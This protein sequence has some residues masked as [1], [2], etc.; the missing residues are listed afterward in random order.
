MLTDPAS[1]TNH[2]RR[3]ISWVVPSSTWKPLDSATR[4][5]D[6]EGRQLWDQ[7]ERVCKF[8]DQARQLTDRAEGR[9]PPAKPPGTGS[10]ATRSRGARR[11]IKQAA[12]GVRKSSNFNKER[13]ADKKL[14]DT[15]ACLMTKRPQSGQLPVLRTETHLL[16]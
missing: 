1:G 15:P 10:E 12:L 8:H 5:R 2:D 11:K 7:A 13:K 6:K 16:A 9:V 3:T 4:P 14:G